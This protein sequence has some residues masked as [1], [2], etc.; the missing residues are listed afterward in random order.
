MEASAKISKPTSSQ[1]RLHFFS[2]YGLAVFLGALIVIFSALMPDTFPT[3]F[4]LRTMLNTQ[5]VVLLLALAEMIPL[6]TENFDLSVGFLV[7]LVHIV[8][9][10]LQNAT[11]IPW[12]VIA[13]L[14][15][16]MGTAYGF[17][18]GILVARV[19]IN[20]FIATLGSGTVLYGIGFWITGGAQVL[21]KNLPESF[22]QI[23]LNVGGI[24]IPIFFV[25]FIGAVLWVLYEYLPLGRYLYALGSNTRAAELVGISR[26]KYVTFTFMASAF[27]VSIAGIILASQLRVAQISTGPNY[28]LPAF[29]GALLGATSI[30]PGRMNVGGTIV[31][32]FLL[33]VAVSGL[34]Q[35]GA[36]FFVEPLFNGTMLIVAVAFAIYMAKRRV[37]TSVAMEALEIQESR[38]SNP[39]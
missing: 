21:G 23:G 14:V 20:A 8:M 11:N 5:S 3:M 28:L 12:L 25:I 39:A 16:V 22:L 33:A 4:N 10:S 37:R 26:V 9:I 31:A 32:V 34:Q 30:R 17:I 15:L 7:G 18:N 13:F 36:E 24:P 27:I 19:G 6:S 29:T 1:S 35:M 38:T 2:T